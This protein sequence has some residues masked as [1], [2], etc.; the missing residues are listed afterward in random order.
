MSSHLPSFKNCI[1]YQDLLHFH[2]NQQL[3]DGS[4]E[5]IDTCAIP[6]STKLR[7]RHK[8]T[9]RVQA[10]TTDTSKPCN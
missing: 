7:A 10:E 1:Q 3:N 2:G 5:D 4:D 6:D 8:S 9:K